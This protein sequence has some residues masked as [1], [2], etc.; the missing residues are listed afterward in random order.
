MH[1]LLRAASAAALALALIAPSAGAA[2]FKT[3]TY[4]GSAEGTDPISFKVAKKKVTNVKVRLRAVCGNPADPFNPLLLTLSPNFATLGTPVSA[5]IASGR[6]SF[7]TDPL[8]AAANG[9]F[10]VK[11]TGRFKP[12]S[13]VTGTVRFSFPAARAGQPDHSD[14]DTGKVA[15]S[16]K[17]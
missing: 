6:F 9:G 15:F 13:K 1:T 7:Q 11:F 12:G 16:A 14:C 5:K 10:T 17:R 4:R 2:T 3:G 8:D